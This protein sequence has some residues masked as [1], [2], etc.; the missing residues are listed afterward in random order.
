MMILLT[1]FTS[2]LSLAAEAMSSAT[3]CPRLVLVEGAEQVADVAE[4]IVEQARAEHLFDRRP[5]FLRC[6]D[7]VDDPALRIDVDHHP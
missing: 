1:S 3:P 6:R 2:S 4:V 5:E 7:R